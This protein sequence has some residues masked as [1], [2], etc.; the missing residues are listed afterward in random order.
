M[1]IDETYIRDKE[2]NK[3]KGKRL[4]TGREAARKTAILGMREGRGRVKAIPINNKDQHTLQQR[5]LI[6]LALAVNYALMTTGNM[7]L[8]RRALPA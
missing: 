1:E 7:Q 2:Q 5:L 3:Y 4:N 6:M 8:R